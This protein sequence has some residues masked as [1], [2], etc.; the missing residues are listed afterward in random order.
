M[1]CQGRLCP[2]W[3]GLSYRGAQHDNFGEESLRHR[4]RQ[5]QMSKRYE[6]AVLT[7]AIDHRQDHELAPDSRQGLHEIQTQVDLDG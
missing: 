7:E 5:V 1:D 3:L 2:R 6:V 4:F